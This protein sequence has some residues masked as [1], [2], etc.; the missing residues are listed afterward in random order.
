MKI[1]IIDEIGP[2][3]IIADDGQKIHDRIVSALKSGTNVNLDFTDVRQFA[4]PFF[5]YAIGQLFSEFSEDV[6]RKCVHLD[7]LNEIGTIVVERVVANA[8]IFRDSKDYKSIVD[9]ILARQSG[10]DK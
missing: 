2:R 3:C 1:R 5:N 4:S 6:V 7:N 9:E 8:L 10:D